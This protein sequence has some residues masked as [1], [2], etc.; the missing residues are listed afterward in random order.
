ML[1]HDIPS[2][3]YNE[4][5]QKIKF[6]SKKWQ[7][8]SVNQL[9]DHISGKKLLKG[10]NVLLTFDDGFLSNRLVADKILNKFNIKALFFVVSN[11]V[12]K[13]TYEEQQSFIKNNLY[14]SWREHDYPSNINEM[15]SMNLED[16]KHLVDCGHTIGFHTSNHLDL[17]SLDESS[18][19]HN[20]V[21]E[22]ALLLEKKLDYKIKH[23]SFG[24]GNVDFFSK[25][26]LIK[27]NSHFAFIHTG[28]RGDNAKSNLSWAL[29]RDTISLD[30]NNLQIASFLEGSSD[31]RYSQ[32]FLKYE[33][34][35]SE[36]LR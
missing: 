9:E 29:R 36:E 18:D 25:K 20:E 35:L 22:G 7:F 13:E 11:F 28:M 12:S 2:D 17:S 19:L 16:L 15:K 1:M 33:S 3:K 10:R 31:L 30:D 34:W 23:F 4:F 24:F 32:D 14:P 8:I 27:A 21:V 6:I 5:T 26:A